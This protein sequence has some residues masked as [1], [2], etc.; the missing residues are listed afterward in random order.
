MELGVDYGVRGRLKSIMPHV[1]IC[2]GKISFQRCLHVVSFSFTCG[3]MFT[4]G[5]F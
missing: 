4:C 5:I 1:D 2:K 3:I